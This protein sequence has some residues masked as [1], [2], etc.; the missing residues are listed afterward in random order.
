MS[1]EM[2]TPTAGPENRKKGPSLKFRYF[3]NLFDE[4]KDGI[5]I[6][7]VR[8][9]RKKGQISEEEQDELLLKLEERS[10]LTETQLIHEGKK[11]DTKV[12]ILERKVEEQA[13]DPVTGF[14]K[15]DS[16]RPIIDDLIRKINNGEKRATDLQV[17]T[18]I[19]VDIDDLRLLN[20]YGHD[21][22]DKGLRALADEIK[23]ETKRNQAFYFRRGDKSDEMIIVLTSTSKTFDPRKIF[24]IIQTKVNT[25]LRI[26][27]LGKTSSGTR[28][29][30]KLPITAAMG[31]AVF[32]RG[33]NK[34]T[35]ELLKEADD[36]QIAD[37][38]PDVKINRKFQAQKL[39]TRKSSFIPL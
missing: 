29:K 28:M 34:T 30:L 3:L 17:I 11:S 23:K 36:N 5:S 21:E 24:K 14:L 4:G 9:A 31:F 25:N 18:V 32:K 7:E 8:E 16:A 1:L 13:V 19:A 33:E 27:V 2:R 22:G 10:A 26:E 37:K 39:I 6:S 35:D 12:E 20:V 38:E 15:F